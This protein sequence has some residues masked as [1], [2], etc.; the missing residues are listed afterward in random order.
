MKSLLVAVVLLAGCQKADGD[1]PNKVESNALH[2]N[3]AYAK[4][5]GTICNAMTLSGADK[6]PGGRL[7][8]VANYLAAHIQTQEAR[9]F[10]I[11]TQPL[12]GAAHAKA[13]DDEAHKVG[14]ADC[15]VSAMWR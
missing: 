13:F 10:M 3:A 15:A 1:A 12:L 14:L 2:T 5:I 8:I 6:D 11:R 7:V 9:D 4:D